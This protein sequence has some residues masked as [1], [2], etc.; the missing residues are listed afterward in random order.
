[1]N[2]KIREY[3]EENE[4]PLLPEYQKKYKDFLIENG[5]GKDPSFVEF[6]TKYSDEMYGSEGHLADVVGDLIDY[7]TACSFNYSM[8]K[9]DEVPKNYISLTD[10]ISEVYLLYNRE[11]G[12]VILIEGAN[13]KRLL[14][15]DFDKEWNSFDSFL[16]DFL[17][18]N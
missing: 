15:G 9:Y 5:F 6:M 11:N 17:E 1:M 10:D 12:H 3:L 13:L 4:E 7:D 16:E 2:N 18:L 14:D 8:H